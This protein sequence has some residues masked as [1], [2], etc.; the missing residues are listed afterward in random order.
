MTC[1]YIGAK[2]LY[3]GDDVDTNDA[4]RAVVAASGMTLADVSRGMGRAPSWLGA[5]L[6][7][8]SSSKA[9]TVAHVGAVCGYDLA[10]VPHDTAPA[11]GVVIDPPADTTAARRAA[12]QREVD[13][14]QAALD[15]ARAALAALEG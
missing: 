10:L 1:D 7:G 2:F 3:G 6:S 4:L 11:G 9:A 13:R 14:A 8:A 5:T 12:A 15:R